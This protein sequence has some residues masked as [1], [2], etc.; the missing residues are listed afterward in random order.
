MKNKNNSTPQ[1]IDGEVWKKMEDAFTQRVKNGL[2]KPREMKAPEMFKL[3][4]R[5]DGFNQSL[6]EI[7]IKPKRKDLI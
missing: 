1:R 7:K 4:G 5:T 3:L 6:N 2:M